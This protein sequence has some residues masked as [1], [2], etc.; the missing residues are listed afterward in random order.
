[1]GLYPVINTLLLFISTINQSGLVFSLFLEMLKIT[2]KLHICT[3][4]CGFYLQKND[5]REFIHVC[6]TRLLQ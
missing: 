1:M 5:L 2:I 6:K 3:A 4:L